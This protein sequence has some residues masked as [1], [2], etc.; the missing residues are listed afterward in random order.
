MKKKKK[1]SSQEIGLVASM[2]FARFF[3]N[4][5]DLHWGYWKDNMEVNMSNLKLAQNN[6][7]DHLI[8]HIP[9]GTKTIL[10]VGSGMGNLAKSLMD[11][12]YEVD[13]VSPSEHLS[14]Q[15]LERIGD[16]TRIHR[17]RYEDLETDKRFDLILFSESFQYVKLKK[18]LEQCTRLLNDGGSMLICDF[19]RH[20]TGSVSALSGGHKW[21]QFLIQL[22]DYPFREETNIDISNFTVPSLELYE[23]FLREVGTPI[24]DL[25]VDYITTG[26]PL[27]TK[28]LAWKNRKRLAKIQRQYFSEMSWIQDFRDH[29]T[30]RLLRYQ[31]C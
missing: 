30:Y 31:K 20:D 11:Q 4:V 14:E 29:K 10:D 2:A 15:I 7:T 13:C 26:Y 17:C 9:E 5:E 27:T 23:S 12:G 25:I 16:E 8:S 19:F 28:M 21:P 3:L 1:G 18:G 6:F 24:K 22:K